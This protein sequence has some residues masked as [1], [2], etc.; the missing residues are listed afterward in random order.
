M[1]KRTISLAA[2]IA[3]LIVIILLLIFCVF[4]R[5]PRGIT[6]SGMIEVLEIQLSARIGGQI[7]TLNVKEGNSIR[8]GDTLVI[9]DHRELTA[10][11]KAA[12]ASLVMAE[13][14]LQEIKAKKS[15]LAR[16]VERIRGL[17]ESGD[18]P[19]NEY[20]AI[21]TQWK[22]ILT[23]E[24]RAEASLK[25][26]RAQLEL[27][28]AQIANAY[29]V[30]PLSGVILALNYDKGESVFPGSVIA[31]IGDLQTAT[32]KIF[33]PEQDVGKI[34]LGQSAQVFVDAYPALVFDG[35]ITW[36][37]SESEFTPRNVQTRDERAQL[38]FAVKITITNESQQLLPGMPADARIVDHG[39]SR[40]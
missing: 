7:Q 39:N 37:S 29:I 40:K 27:I 1:K 25:A 21:L 6:G 8:E 20:E 19:D 12:S 24:T 28:Q 33:V 15:D 9:L 32:L 4:N 30:S 17:H 5:K 34:T 14:S 22:V 36:I 2:I 26:A 31:K 10:Q 23:Q 18:V 11:E 3:V 35:K 38:V 13:Q 16:N